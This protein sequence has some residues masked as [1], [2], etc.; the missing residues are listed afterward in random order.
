[1]VAYAAVGLL[2]LTV[3]GWLLLGGDS[4]P[5]VAP[6]TIETIPEP[7]LIEAE[8]V[9]VSASV[10]LINE[11]NQQA[12]TAMLEERVIAPKGD[13]ALEYYDKV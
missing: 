9:S 1:M 10:Q 7:T 13:N 11:L 6:I 5:E 3:F 8:D 4:E 2:I 12:A